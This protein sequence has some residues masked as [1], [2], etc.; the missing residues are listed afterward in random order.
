M[1]KASIAAFLCLVSV[2]VFAAEYHVAH[3]GND[4]NPGTASAPFATLERARDAVR[5]LKQGDGLPEGGV[6]VWI[7][8][9][10]YSRL[11]P[12]CLGEQDSG[13]P[14]SRIAYRAVDGEDVHLIGG[15]EVAGG[16]FQAV[17]DEAVLGR[18]DESARGQVVV[19]DLRALGLAD[20]GVFPDSY[21]D[22][23][24]VPEVF[25]DG[26]RMT[27]ARWPNDGWAHITA[28]VESGPAPWRN[29]E[30]AQPGTFQ[31]EGD[32]PARWQ[33]APGVWL[34]GYWC[35]DW[36][37]ETIR[38]GSIDI[39]K[40]EITL[41]KPHVY[42][43]GGGNPSPRR[44]MALNL[45]E[46]LDSPGEYYLDRDAGKLYFW[47]PRPVMEGHVALSLT[48]E[49]VIQVENA[50]HVTFRGL[51][52]E[53]CAGDGIVMR[54]GRENELLACTIRRTGHAG[55]LVDGGAKHGVRAC[56]IYETG[57]GGLYI[58]GGDRTT[59][60]PS[61]HTVFN[62]H[63]HHVG[64]RKRT[65]A[66]HLHLSGVGIH[67]AHNLFHDA[68]HQ[69]IGLAGNDHLI[70]YNEISH[71]G[72][73]SDDCGAFY[74]GR[75]PS[76]RG[77]V[78]RY[79]FW[80]HTGSERAHGSAAIYFD[81]GAGGQTVF[82]NVFYKAAGGTF[83]AVFIHG[84]HDNLVDNNVF[85]ECSMAMRQAAWTDAAWRSFL[86]DEDRQ[87]KLLRDVDITRPPYTEKYP[88]LRGYM[89][90]NGEP[91]LNKACRNIVCNCDAFIGGNW[92]IINNWVMRDEDPGFVDPQNLNFQLRE[93]SV[94][95]KRVE[96]F[97]PIPFEEI[98]L[99]KDELR[100]VLPGEE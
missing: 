34:Y 77:T 30:S 82:G 21:G 31:Y 38:A 88:E 1:P 86:D 98:G 56:D 28:V 70:E 64:E 80:H 12:F 54:E 48:K 16:A 71:S 67:V 92:I 59:L 37:S 85:I 57:M 45:L 8:G 23:P 100:P 7:H 99:V 20:Y 32:R 69:S 29:H 63:I 14:G 53:M 33:S 44:Y 46:E 72:L 24:I 81:D 40:R 91:R 61:E 94:I 41:V 25:F 79:N 6:T 55:V 2:W 90:W 50:S 89:E 3:D 10:I 87:N 68:P 27:L 66:Y 51:T 93:D 39:G 96:G 15:L 75:N 83:G 62:N 9:G 58:G 36:S 95:L 76:E 19:A 65:H 17:R 73:E 18:I 84:G 47:P 52:V 78:L 35:F 97:Q 42:G 43:I 26:Q 5:A 4:G 22:P 49:P 13:T 74:M 11:A 60:T